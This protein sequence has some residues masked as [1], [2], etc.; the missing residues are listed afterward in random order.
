V[1]I[2][3]ATDTRIGVILLGCATALSLR[4][5]SAR[6]VWRRI[7]RSVELP[8]V[9][10]VLTALCVAFVT[11]GTPSSASWRS[12]TFGYTLEA[13]A[14]AA[15]MG[16]VFIQPSSIVARALSWRPL[17]G[18]GRISYG[19]Y[20]FHAPIAW[21]ALHLITPEGLGR[22]RSILVVGMADSAF[23]PRFGASAYLQ[24]LAM[25]NPAMRFTFVS[26]IVLV[27]TSIVAGLHFRYV[28]RHAASYRYERWRPRTSSLS[29]G[30]L[31]RFQT[32]IY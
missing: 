23:V 15:L 16:A 21:L 10:V 26:A 29:T 17:A 6:L 13:C 24:S 11:G 4:H 28:E 22:I 3:F 8:E 32:L 9:F 31:V 19:V 14:S 27:A 5:R 12:A 30:M 7:R 18:L 2:Y 20:L 1:W 25:M